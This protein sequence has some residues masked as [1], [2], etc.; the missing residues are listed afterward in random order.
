MSR[1]C[2]REMVLSHPKFRSLV[3]DLKPYAFVYLVG[4]L[5]EHPVGR[6]ADV[7]AYPSDE[8]AWGRVDEYLDSRRDVVRD[9]LMPSAEGFI[10]DLG[11]FRV[12]LKVFDPSV[13]LESYGCY[14]SL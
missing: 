13:P 7:V 11:D 12:D 2:T 1:F 4:S 3:A 14:E 5:C 10:I 9:M 6:D 8:E